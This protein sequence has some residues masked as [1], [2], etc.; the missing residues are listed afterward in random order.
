MAS[1]KKHRKNLQQIEN[2]RR[3]RDGWDEVEAEETRLLRQMTIKESLGHL[4]L[5]QSA[6]E[7]QLQR[8]ESLFRPERLAYLQDLQ[9][10]LSRLANWLKNRRGHP[11]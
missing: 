9:N 7:S 3:I 6:F 5:L 4:L 1:L 10:R 8:T 2:L 11:V